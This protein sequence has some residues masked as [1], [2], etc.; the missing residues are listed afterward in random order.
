[1]PNKNISRKHIFLAVLGAAVVLIIGIVIGRK[2]AD[3]PKESLDVK[4]SSSLGAIREAG[5]EYINPLL[6]CEGAEES[7][8][9]LTPF[10]NK[11]QGYIETTTRNTRGIDLVSVYFRDLNNGPWFGINEKENFSPASLLKVPL[12]IAYFKQAEED[13]EILKKFL[14]FERK[15]FPNTV[16]TILPSQSIENGKSYTVEDLISRM[17]IY[18]DNNA[19]QL[20]LENIEDKIFKKVYSDF[21]LEPIEK[22]AVDTSVTVKTYAGFFRMLFNASYLNKTYSEKSLKLLLGSEFKD[23]LVAGVPPATPVAHKFGERSF[24]GSNVKQLHDCGIIYY[25]QHPYLVCVMSRGENAG[26]LTS[27]IHN[28]SGL[29]YKEVDKQIIQLP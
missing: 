23:G 2:T 10:K 15:G 1:V 11:I 4:N 14:V 19:Q 13:P 5:Y 22:N 28:I 6:E 21:G 20:L 12:M 25:P 7:F 24:L 29:I 9:E 8:V 26:D 18:S 3:C 17:I 16:Q 27:I